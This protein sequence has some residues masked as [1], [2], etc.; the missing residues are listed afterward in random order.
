M[1][2]DQKNGNNADRDPSMQPGKK[3]LDWEKYLVGVFFLLFA[4]LLLAAII[5]FKN[6]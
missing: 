1:N 2:D 5:M 3:T 4:I 6:A